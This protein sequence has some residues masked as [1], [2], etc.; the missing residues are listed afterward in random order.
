ME[1]RASEAGEGALPSAC[2]PPRPRHLNVRDE[3]WARLER[4]GGGNASR[5]LHLL[6]K[7]DRIWRHK[8]RNLRQ[9][10]VLWADEY[11]RGGNID[12]AT[13]LRNLSNQLAQWELEAEGEG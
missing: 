12:A 2:G 8:I 13:L 5:G 11:Q 6:C 4:R 9:P 7:I 1:N 10:L 3:D